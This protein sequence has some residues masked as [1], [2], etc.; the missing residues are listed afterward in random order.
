MCLLLSLLPVS[1]AQD[2]TDTARG[3]LNGLRGRSPQERW[4][5]VKKQYPLAPVSPP[6][7]APSRLTDAQDGISFQGQVPPSPE[8]LPL[9]P[10]LSAL[11]TNDS[12]DWILPARP[13]VAGGDDTVPPVVP[14]PVSTDGPA[15]A[16][17]L[18]NPPPAGEAAHDYEAPRAKARQQ[19]LAGRLFN[20]F[21]LPGLN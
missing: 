8:Q 2:D 15:P 21:N 18:K 19:T 9:I 3:M 17:S 12:N 14:S 1:Y 10:R 16:G 7:M 5:R 13:P 4:E 20:F 6:Q 11:P